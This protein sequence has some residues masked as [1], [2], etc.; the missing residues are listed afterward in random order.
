LR[1]A[2][3][4]HSWVVYRM[5]AGAKHAAMNGVCEESEWAALAAD[6][7]G[8]FTLIQGGIPTEN[9]AERVA[10]CVPVAV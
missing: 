7:Q 1:K 2:N 9:E 8:R 3:E 4:C 6:E 10:R 5:A